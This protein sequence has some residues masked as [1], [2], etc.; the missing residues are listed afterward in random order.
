MAKISPWLLLCLF[1]INNKVMKRSEEIRSVNAVTVY[2]HK[3]NSLLLIYFV[4]ILHEVDVWKN[5]IAVELL[6]SCVSSIKAT[7]RNCR[8]MKR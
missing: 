8:T 6:V 3:I 4:Y 2:G 5:F 7:M 1:K